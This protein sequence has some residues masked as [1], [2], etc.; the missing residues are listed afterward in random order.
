MS[1]MNET[2]CPN[3]QQHLI[4]YRVERQPAGNREVLLQWTICTHCRHVALDGW[5]FAD[6]PL[7]NSVS[8]KAVY[9]KPGE[10]AL[11]HSHSS[12]QRQAARQR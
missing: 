1:E 11:R 9:M 7:P 5:S 3:C 12:N 8:G 4:D 2:L 6:G 10:R